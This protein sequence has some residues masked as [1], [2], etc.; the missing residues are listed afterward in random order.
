VAAV[1]LL[2]ASPLVVLAASLNT[3][4]L[5]LHRA[6]LADSPTATAPTFTLDPSSTQ[7][8]APRPNTQPATP[9]QTSPS[10]ALNITLNA[11]EALA[12]GP[13]TPRV[14]VAQALDA[15]RRH[16]PQQE[17]AG[18]TQALARGGGW[19]ASIGLR[20][21]DLSFIQG[22]EPAAVQAWHQANAVQP[23]LDQAAGA[24]PAD[25]L[26][27]YALAEA[28]QPADWRAFVYSTRLIPNSDPRLSAALAQALQA[29]G[30]QPARSAVAARLLT[31]LA[32]L[33]ATSEPPARSTVDGELFTRAAVTFLDRQD[34][35]A[36]KL[37]AEF[38]TIAAPTSDESWQTL[39]TVLERAGLRAQA[40]QARAHRR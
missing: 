10:E 9:S 12:F 30:D 23:L 27:W 25:A 38:A 20:L 32:V 21:G 11:A 33:P 18:F 4:T 40:D 31:P 19:D 13:F 35:A 8:A 5:L 16:D 6:I 17:I 2:I 15:T 7:P 39:A 36:A 22:N 14:A 34:L 29:P 1:L 28:V 24:P 26:R 3:A 37:A